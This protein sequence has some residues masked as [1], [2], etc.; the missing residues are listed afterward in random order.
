[1]VDYLDTL[2]RDPALDPKLLLT[3]STEKDRKSEIAYDA[4]C[5]DIFNDLKCLFYPN[6]ESLTYNKIDILLLS[7][8]FAILCNASDLLHT[9]W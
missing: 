4:I 7:F 5:P 1:M 6:D 2:R 8:P 9:L 3:H